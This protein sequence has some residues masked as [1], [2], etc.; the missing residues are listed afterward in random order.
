MILVT[1]VAR[2]GTS[3]TTEILRNLG[4]W[5]GP[6]GDVNEF[7]ENLVVREYLVKGYLIALDADPL[8]Q[9]PLPDTD[10]LP[11]VEGFRDLVLERIRGTGTPIAYKDAKIC[12]MWPVWAD[13]FP[14]AKWVLVRRDPDRIVDSCIRT[15][16]MSRFGNDRTEWRRWVDEYERRL[17]AIHASS[18]DS[19]EIWPDEYVRRPQ[20]FAPIAEFCDLEFDPDAVLRCCDRDR[21]KG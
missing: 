8:G 14:E 12:L 13:A 16:F 5:L 4:C 9:D 21:W 19:V 10:D 2:S 3:L 11:L 6:A 17:A 18:C 7:Q 1:G 20:A 15:P